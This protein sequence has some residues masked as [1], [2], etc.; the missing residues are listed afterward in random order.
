MRSFASDNFSGVHPEILQAIVNVNIDHEFAY[1]YDSYT[2]KAIE[3]FR[4]RFGDVDVFFV[5]TG[6]GANVLGLKAI[7][8][9]YDAVLCPESAHINTN[10]C[11]AVESIVGSHIIPIT[12]KDGKISVEDIRHYLHLLGDEHHAQPRVISISQPTE[13][14][15]LYTT[16]EIRALSDFAHE[17][18]M[19]LHMDGA[20]I[21]NAVAAMGVSFREITTDVGVDVLSFGGTKN[22]MMM[23]EAVV[24]L[25]KAL[26]KGF[27]YIRKQSTQLASKMRFISAQFIA[28]FTNDLY[29]KNATH[30]NRMAKLLAEGVKD[31]PKVRIIQRVQTNAVFATLPSE[32]IP[33]LQEEYFFYVIDEDASIVRWMCS[34]DTTEEDVNGFLSLLK[35]VLA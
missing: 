21:S 16:D 3:M 30:A 23:G 32:Y 34:F 10:E 28:F 19:Y 25:N 11:G 22:G 15:T 1:G 24:F 31:I 33:R 5:F 29:L 17:N 9:S 20:R 2:K 35:Q 6:T 27:K 13:F 4:E 12:T 8:R 26:S 7:M 14:G 18:G